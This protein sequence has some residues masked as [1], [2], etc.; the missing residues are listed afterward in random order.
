MYA[1]PTPDPRACEPGASRRRRRLRNQGR[2]PQ[3]RHIP[4]RPA[5]SGAAT[6][7]SR[8]YRNGYWSPGWGGVGGVSSAAGSVASALVKRRLGSSGTP[9]RR[10]SLLAGSQPV[11]GAA[12]ATG[13]WRPTCTDPG[14]PRA[15]TRIRSR[16][17][18]PR[19]ACA[20]LE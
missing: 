12:G 18:V 15:P 19:I 2:A 13:V 3:G 14:R 20:G 1:R 11:P 4:T 17:A 5:G 7:D 10:A 16:P 9:V 8:S 6:A